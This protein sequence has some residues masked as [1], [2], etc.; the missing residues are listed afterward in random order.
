MLSQ[1]KIRHD[2]NRGLV[3]FCKV[4]R[5][6]GQ[7]KSLFDIS[8]SKDDS[9]E[10]SLRC[11][12]NLI[13]ISLFSLCWQ[14]CRGN[15]D[16]YIVFFGVRRKKM[17]CAGCWRHRVCNIHLEASCNSSKTHCLSTRKNIFFLSGKL[18]LLSQRL[19]VLEEIIVPFPCCLYIHVSN[20]TFVSELI[21]Y[22][23]GQYIEIDARCR[24]CSTKAY[25]VF[26]K[27]IGTVLCRYVRQWHGAVRYL[28]LPV[29]FY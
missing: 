15:F 5:F 7:V 23:A 28:F 10:V 24:H 1:V 27:W 6:P 19:K 22:N 17:Q 26:Q 21:L 14:A 8:W 3:F 20:G 12:Q 11:T 29:V 25:G 2:E 18:H 4:H 9:H 13:Q 16:E